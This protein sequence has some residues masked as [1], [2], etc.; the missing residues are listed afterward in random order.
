[1]ERINKSIPYFLLGILIL[2]FLIFSDQ[3]RFVQDDAYITFRYVKNFVDGNG[4][5]FNV[6]EYVEGYTSILWVMLLVPFSILNI[7]L[8]DAAQTMS[9]VFGILSILMTFRLS[10]LLM[11]AK[12]KGEFIFNLI[13]PLLL[14]FSNA[15]SYWSVSGM[16]T[17]LFI[18][19]NLTAFYFYIVQQTTEA[20]N[21]RLIITLILATLTRPEGMLT[22][23]IFYFFIMIK[24]KKASEQ[25]LNSRYVQEIVIY[26]IPIGLLILFRLIYYGHPLPNTY[27]AKTGSSPFYLKRGLQYFIDFSHYYM[28]YGSLFLLLIPNMFNKYR[29][30]KTTLL[31][32]IVFTYI[33]T[34]MVIGGDVLP[35]HRFFLPILPF[36]YILIALSLRN[37]Y[38]SFTSAL[39]G[40]I[41]L[42]LIVCFAL[43]SAFFIRYKESARVDL[44]YRTE[45][46][47]VAKMKEYAEFIKH[48]ES[49]RGEKLTI[50]ASTIGAISYY[51]EVE[52][53]DLL[54]LTDEFI[55]HNPKELTGLTE[56]AP[57][58]WREKHY[59]ADY[60]LSREPD[61]IIFP[62]GS[63][64]SGFPES[65]VFLNEQF[66]N[67][68]YVELFY[69]QSLGQQL[70]IFT[71]KPAALAR[72]RIDDNVSCDERFIPHYINANNFLL[73]YLKNNN[74]VLIERIE[75]ES[76]LVIE[77]CPSMSSKINTL[78]GM[79]YF[80]SGNKELALQKLLSAVKSDD[81]DCI[82]HFY[83]KNIYSELS[84]SAGIIRHLR[85]LKKYSPESI[86]N[87]I[88]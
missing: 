47:L 62:A 49:E 68:Y 10:R 17:S 73:A 23:I 34:I 50:A 48:K 11:P 82:A 60:V 1:V 20:P 13:P 55:A 12:K 45:I 57:E 43:S 5:V 63:K 22:F 8:P 77:I 83:L 79:T 36:I 9:L 18:L 26:L 3:I 7:S 61:Y 15:F 39:K 54:G 29:G 46:G 44:V 53:V 65:A 4:L 27:Y 59:N 69:S 75:K 19:L 78:L 35:M 37:I 81:L 32:T 85:K 84:D 14:I 70:P 66:K 76:Q 33:V 74:P 30:N 87:F 80:H 2:L 56:A 51:S 38:D 6:G 31:L 41:L 86:P 42:V 72:N 71:R 28:I 25:L 52:L 88:D 67:N 40:N 58:T 24:N 16:E 64:P 21:Y